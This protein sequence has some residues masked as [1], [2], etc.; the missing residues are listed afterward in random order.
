MKIKFPKL[1][2]FLKPRVKSSL[3]YSG[4]LIL[5][6]VIIAIVDIFLKELGN[7]PHLIFL[8]ALLLLLGA[9][10]IQVLAIDRFSCFSNPEKGLLTLG[11]NLVGVIIF[12][13]CS[14]LVDFPDII[15]L[16]GFIYLPAL[17]FFTLPW[18]L[19]QSIRSILAIP[20]LRYSPIVIKRLPIAKCRFKDHSRGIIWIFEENFFEKDE[21]GRFLFRTFLPNGN[22]DIPLGELF[23][24]VLSLHNHDK[25]PGKP[26][27]LK[28]KPSWYGWSFYHFPHPRLRATARA[29]DPL[30]PLDGNKIH[31]SQLSLEERPKEGRQNPKLPAKFKVTK[32][33]VKRSLNH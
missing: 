5:A 19:K 18:I 9:L 2:F 27:H 12:I 24:A 10:N 14:P 23:E 1:D 20:A 22:P 3:L 7:K 33:Y 15:E 25:E 6:F 17:L 30:R 31:F 8:L 21:S 26:I 16:Y 13:N 29:L 28:S 4:F 11:G 32:I